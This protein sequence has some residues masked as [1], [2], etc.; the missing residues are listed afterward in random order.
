V[1]RGGRLWMVDFADG[2]ESHIWDEIPRY[3][4]TRRAAQEWCDA[5]HEW[6]G[7]DAGD[8]FVVRPAPDDILYRDVVW[9]T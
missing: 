1:R 9:E 7:F 5:D 4:T 3:F 8:M 6:W 2:R